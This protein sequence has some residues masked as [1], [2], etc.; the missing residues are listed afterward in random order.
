M[1]T[2]RLPLFLDYLKLHYAQ[3]YQHYLGRLTELFPSSE[4][5]EENLFIA[6][7]DDDDPEEDAILLR[8][9]KIFDR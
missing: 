8:L 1:L 9:W 2:Y 7:E 3:L 4:P 6:N 5:T